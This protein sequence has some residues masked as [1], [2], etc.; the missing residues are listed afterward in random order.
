MFIP[1]AVFVELKISAIKLYI[2]GS[3]DRGSFIH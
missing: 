1:S 3:F 2:R